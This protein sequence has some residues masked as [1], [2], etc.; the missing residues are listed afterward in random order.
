MKLDFIIKMYLRN[1][2]E[3]AVCILAIKMGILIRNLKSNS[4]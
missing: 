1:K 4:I 2:K 3:R